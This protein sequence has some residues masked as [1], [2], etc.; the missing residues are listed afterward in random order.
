[1]RKASVLPEPV[2]A[3]ARMSDPLSESGI[4]S[5]WIGVGDWKKAFLRPGAKGRGRRVAGQ[6]IRLVDNLGTSPPGAQGRVETRW[7]G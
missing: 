2:R 6:R 7:R 3:E 5:D 4:E 1:M